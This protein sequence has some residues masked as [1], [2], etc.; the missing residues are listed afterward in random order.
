VPAFRLRIGWS[1]WAC[2]HRNAATARVAVPRRK[3]TGPATICG[4]PPAAAPVTQTCPDGSVIAA[5]ESCPS[6]AP[7]RRSA[8]PA[9]RGE[10]GV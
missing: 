7:P 10:H 5:T 9:D 2:L 4:D 1:G 8:A 6:P 3:K